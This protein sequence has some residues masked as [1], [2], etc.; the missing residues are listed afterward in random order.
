M[1]LASEETRRTVLKIEIL[2]EV[3]NWPMASEYLLKLARGQSS[4]AGREAA[5]YILRA[6]KFAV[7]DYYQGYYFLDGK[8]IRLPSALKNALFTL[9]QAYSVAAL[10]LREHQEEMQRHLLSYSQLY[11]MESQMNSTNAPSP[12][13]DLSDDDSDLPELVDHNIWDDDNSD[14]SE[15]IHPDMH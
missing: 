1:Q 3:G 13:S 15:L 6:I 9:Q 4:S 2:M 10:E 8:K 11:H 12:G 7:S 14:M 5:K